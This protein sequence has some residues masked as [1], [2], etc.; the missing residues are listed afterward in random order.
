MEVFTSHECKSK[1]SY[2]IHIIIY[3][4]GRINSISNHL[5]YITTSYNKKY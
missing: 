5:D 3:T 2:F 4:E 1:F